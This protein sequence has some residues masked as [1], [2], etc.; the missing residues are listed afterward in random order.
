MIDA[1]QVIATYIYIFIKYKKHREFVK[2]VKAKS[3]T[4]MQFKMLILT[5]LI[6]IFAM[7]FCIPDFVI[8]IFQFRNVI[9]NGLEFKILAQVYKKLWLADPVIFIYNWKLLKKAKLNPWSQ[10]YT[11][12]NDKISHF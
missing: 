3:N 11:M 1:V 7:F 2:C 6:V 4:R 9:P 10:N 8:I 5:L 12:S